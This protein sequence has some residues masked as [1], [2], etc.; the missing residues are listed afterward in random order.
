MNEYSIT[1]TAIGQN[2]INYGGW[3]QFVIAPNEEKAKAEGVRVWKAIAGATAH[4]CEATSAKLLGTAK[5][6][7]CCGRYGCGTAFNVAA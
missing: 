7:G 3:H 2:G 5:P 1:G 6:C 4:I